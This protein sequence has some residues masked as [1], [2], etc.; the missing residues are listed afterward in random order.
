[1]KLSDPLTQEQLD[2][3]FTRLGY[4]LRE[5]K[6][7][8]RVWENPEYDAVTLLPVLSPEQPARLHHLLA[9]RRI[10]IEKGIVEPDDFDALLEQARQ[11]PQEPVGSHNAA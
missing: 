8:P 7:G 5:V 1:M 2:Y 3:L 6:D 10:A 4:R 9:L 11:Y